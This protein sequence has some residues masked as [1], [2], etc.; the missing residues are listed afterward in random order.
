MVDNNIVNNLGMNAASK[1][2]KRLQISKFVFQ[3]VEPQICK[4]RWRW[5]RN[6]SDAQ[7]RARSGAGHSSQNYF[8]NV[9][10]FLLFY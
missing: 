6:N 7:K 2:L 4:R 10:D 9:D 8:V 3:D 5:R 1:N